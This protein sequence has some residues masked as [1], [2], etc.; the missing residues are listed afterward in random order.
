[1]VYTERRQDR[2]TEIQDTI[3]GKKR[4][5]SQNGRSK[6]ATSIILVNVKVENSPLN[7]KISYM[8]C[9]RDI[10]MLPY[11]YTLG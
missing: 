6:N 9:A 2:G 8:P 5:I 7:L 3:R 4:N 10:I 11:F 1:M